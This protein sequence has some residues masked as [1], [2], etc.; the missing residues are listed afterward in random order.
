MDARE[1]RTIQGAR[2]IRIRHDK[3]DKIGFIS[4]L[5]EI[6]R[7]SSDSSCF[8]VVYDRETAKARSLE[9]ASCPT[10]VVRAAKLRVP[11]RSWRALR[12]RFASRKARKGRKGQ[13]LGRDQ[14]RI[15][16]TVEGTGYPLRSVKCS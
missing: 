10:P 15:T 16:R 7:S 11:L 8:P 2:E 1:R 13:Q 4:F 6:G 14:K 5:L 9:F 3:R 12:E